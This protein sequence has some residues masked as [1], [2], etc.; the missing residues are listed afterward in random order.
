VFATAY[1]QYAVR[2]FDVNAVDYLLKPFDRSRVQQAVE[3]VRSR[4]PAEGEW[5]DESGDSPI[6][7][8]LEALLRLLNKPQGAAQPAKLP[9]RLLSG[10][11][12]PAAGGPGGDLLRG[13]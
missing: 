8:Q 5:T 9:A 6:E 7:S 11:E 2:A 10:A 13:H 3:R 12:S 1:D 4:M